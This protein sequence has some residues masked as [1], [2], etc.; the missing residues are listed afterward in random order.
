MQKK[1]K[2]D[3]SQ[4]WRGY[5]AGLSAAHSGK[6]NRSSNLN[7]RDKEAGQTQEKSSQSFQEQPVAG[8][9][10]FAQQHSQSATASTF[11]SSN[12]NDS[13]ATSG[14]AAQTYQEV[15]I[16]GSVKSS[17]SCGKSH[18]TAGLLA[19]FLGMLGLHKFYLGYNSAGFVMLAVTILGSLFS[20]GLAGLAMAVI[21]FVEGIIYLAARQKDFERT[22]IYNMKQWF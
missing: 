1:D 17:Y 10:S 9:Y 14:T 6:S 7:G 15:P 12:Q 18:V 2:K 13:F 16:S 5:P 11:S 21:G 20:F 3:N 19:I 22:Y 4:Y 8:S